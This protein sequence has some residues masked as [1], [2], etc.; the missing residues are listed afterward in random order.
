MADNLITVNLKKIHLILLIAGA[1]ITVT[2]PAVS[3][4]ISIGTNSKDIGKLDTRILYLEKES[5]TN[6][7]LLLELKF[8]LKNHMIAAGEQYIDFKDEKKW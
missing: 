7:D 4:F 1:L 5:Q 8:N 2:A 3:A 6:H